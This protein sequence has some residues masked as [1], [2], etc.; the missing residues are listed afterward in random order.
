MGYREKTPRLIG[1]RLCL[2]FA[3]TAD[4][5]D[6]VVVL[7]DLEGPADLL[8]WAGHLRLL[9]PEAAPGEAE[10]ARALPPLRRFRAALYRLFTSEAAPAAE[11]L[12]E[13]DAWLRRVP[14]LRAAP[15]G[16][17]VYAGDPDPAVAV[18]GPV[19]VSAAELLAGGDRERVR[20]CPGD[21]CG[22]L[23]LDESR[24]GRR[25]WCSM[26]TCGNRAKAR[27][28]YRRHGGA[29]GVSVRPGSSGH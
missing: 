22:W 8:I 24:N 13:L 10:T 12:A 23:F 14:P 28:H 17:L 15:D 29:R 6:G 11:D 19:A 4:W 5:R 27:A 3:N 7:E 1:G 16:R 25:R 18:A 20:R 2:D 21:D 26:Q 9:G